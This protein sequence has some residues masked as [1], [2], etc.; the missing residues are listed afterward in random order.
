MSQTLDEIRE[1]AIEELE[2]RWPE[3]A[4]S[5]THTA[6]DGCTEIADSSV[7]IYTSEL[8]ALAGDPEVAN[9]ENEL[10]PAFDGKPTITNLV[11]TA[12][13][14]IV[15]SAVHT[16]LYELREEWDSCVCHAT[17]VCQDCKDDPQFPVNENG[18]CEECEGSTVCQECSE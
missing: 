2:G 3:W 1:D 13:Y 11:A 16:R 5:A 6:D 7:P 18:D 12:V 17:Q 15:S 9:H 4:E 8:A 14:E 10:G